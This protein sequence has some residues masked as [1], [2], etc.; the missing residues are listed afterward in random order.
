MVLD[1]EKVV[2]VPTIAWVELVDGT[3]LEAVYL[4]FEF[5]ADRAAATVSFAVG[6]PIGVRGDGVVPQKQITNAQAL[7]LQLDTPVKVFAQANSNIELPGLPTEPTLLLDGFI[8]DSGPQRISG[9]SNAFGYGIEVIHRDIANLSTGSTAVWPFTTSTNFDWKRKTSVFS[10]MW[11]TAMISQG[12]TAVDAIKGDGLWATLRNYFLAVARGAEEGQSLLGDSSLATACAGIS[13]FDGIGRNQV[14]IDAL[15]TINSVT[16]F[17]IA[18][19]D[20]QKFV[21]YLDALLQN[22]MRTMSFWESLKYLSDKLFFRIVPKADGSLAVVPFKTFEQNALVELSGDQI[23]QFRPSAVGDPRV[24]G[25]MLYA[26]P[27]AQSAFE[28]ESIVYGCFIF[29]GESF[30][31]RGTI[32]A[33]EAPSWL[34]PNAYPYSPHTRENLAATVEASDPNADAA[35]EVPLEINYRPTLERFGSL[36]ARELARQYRFRGSSVQFSSY[37]RT[38][39]GVHSTVRVQAP[40]TIGDETVLFGKVD[41]VG[42]VIDGGSQT[43]ETSYTLAYVHNGAVQESIDDFTHPIFGNESYPGGPL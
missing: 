9:T 32:E 35:P 3:Q 27:V 2:K 29:D 20:I 1:V 26:P 42:I 30:S 11:M 8:V 17:T 31:P 34:G 21:A 14:A 39:I 40:G 13:G 5:S 23:F 12:T 38:D 4:S 6:T 22:D 37:L 16:P 19:D 10:N 28:D 7:Q 43:A 33:V 15:S 36:V 25:V 41:R 18:A 24:A